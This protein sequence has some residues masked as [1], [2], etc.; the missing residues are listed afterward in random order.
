[1]WVLHK[2]QTLCQG[3]LEVSVAVHQLVGQGLNP[4]LDSDWT[5][6]L[7]KILWIIR[8][9]QVILVQ[10]S[11]GLCLTI[12]PEMHLWRQSL[13][14]GLCSKTPK[15]KELFLVKVRTPCGSVKFFHNKLGH[16]CLYGLS[17]CTDARWSHLQT[18]PKFGALTC[19][20]SKALRCF[21]IHFM[22]PNTSK[23]ICCFS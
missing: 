23:L 3:W 2:P 1:M 20:R 5:F 10:A 16:P 11:A 7:D 4:R 14:H 17:L 8:K 6:M 9:V 13:A 18:V 21:N 15:K 19:R 22:W 12:L